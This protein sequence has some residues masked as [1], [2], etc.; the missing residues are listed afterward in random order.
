MVLAFWNSLLFRSISIPLPV[1]PVRSGVTPVAVIIL[2]PTPIVPSISAAVPVTPSIIAVAIQ[3]VTSARTITTV[4]FARF[5]PVTTYSPP[6][7]VS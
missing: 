4:V 2:L 1:P 6:R 5:S 7:S 3:L